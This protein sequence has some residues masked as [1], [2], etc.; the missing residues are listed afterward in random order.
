MDIAKMRYQIDL[1]DQLGNLVSRTL[2]LLP[3][4]GLQPDESLVSDDSWKSCYDELPG[5]R[6]W[7]H[8]LASESYSVA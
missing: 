1:A 7:C 3:P 5:T 2:A 6:M 8:S 4:D